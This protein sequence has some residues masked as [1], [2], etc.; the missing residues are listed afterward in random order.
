MTFVLPYLDLPE[1]V[2][3]PAGSWGPGSAPLSLKPFGILVAS[4]VYLGALCAT[5]YGRRRGIDSR[6]LTSFIFHVVGAGTAWPCC[7]TRT[8]SPARSLSVG[9]SAARAAPSFTIIRG[10]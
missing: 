1:I 5:R 8:S 9:S 4:G 7:P 10:S 3:L 2:L 6:V